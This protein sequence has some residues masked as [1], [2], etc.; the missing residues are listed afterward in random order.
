MELNEDLC[1]VSATIFS[2]D[3]KSAVRSVFTEPRSGLSD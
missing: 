1:C 2:I 3:A